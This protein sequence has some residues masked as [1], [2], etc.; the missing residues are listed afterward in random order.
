MVVIKG[1]A[2]GHAVA[3]VSRVALQKFSV[4]GLPAGQR[5]ST[6]S[7]RRWTGAVAGQHPRHQCGPGSEPEPRRRPWRLDPRPVLGCLPGRFRRAGIDCVGRSPQ[8]PGPGG[9]ALPGRWVCSSVVGRAL[10]IL[11]A[12]GVAEELSVT[13]QATRAPGGLPS[14]C[15]CLGSRASWSATVP[16]TLQ[17]LVCAWSGGGPSAWRRPPTMSWTWVAVAKSMVSMAKSMVVLGAPLMAR[18]YA[19]V[20]NDAAKHARGGASVFETR[21]LGRVSTLSHRLRGV[22]ISD[23]HQGEDERAPARTDAGTSMRRVSAAVY[24]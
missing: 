16:S 6:A 19:R 23:C 24:W 12:L 1:P 5:G 18:H 13:V 17:A 14:S 7:R 21:A 9:G 15:T 10:A 20:G 2:H 4:R 3:V 22:R 8:R 11:I